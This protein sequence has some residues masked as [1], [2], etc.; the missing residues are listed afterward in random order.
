MKHPISTA[1]LLLLWSPL[2]AQPADEWFK[3]ND[4]GNRFEGSYSQKVSNPSVNLVS[5]TA[6]TAKYTLGQGQQLQVRF[7]NP[8][9]TEYDLHAEELNVTQ[10][11]WMQEKN[12]SSAKGWQQFAGW[13]VDMMLKRL[14]IDARNLGVLVRLGERG[15]RKFSPAYVSLAGETAA[16]PR[17]FI[18]QLRLGRAAADGN[19]KVYKGE[20]RSKAS[21]LFEQKISAKASGTTFPIV[22]AADKLGAEASW[23]TVE[24][25]FREKGSLDPFTYS[26]SFYRQPAQ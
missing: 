18:A 23:F 12:K 10:F 25:N 3:Q 15:G 7:Y 9:V 4:R 11:Y 8:G 26:F 16:A 13:Q 17:N 5:L 24:V 21:L 6:S 20:S 1:I 2:L 22:I 19:F 14:S